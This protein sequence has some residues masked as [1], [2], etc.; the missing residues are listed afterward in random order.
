MLTTIVGNASGNFT[1]DPVNDIV[2]TTITLHNVKQG[3]QLL[4]K[5]SHGIIIYKEEIKNAGTYSKG[6]DL[7][8]L[9]DGNYVFE[10]EKDVEI[11]SIPFKINA[12]TVILNNN[13]PTIFKP[14]ITSKNNYL[15]LTKLALNNEP[16]HVKIY[17]EEDELLYSEKIE[18]TKTIEKAYKLIAPGTYKIVL[19]SNGRTYYQNIKL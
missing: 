16:L 11:K 6:F 5:D 9:P 2:K 7:T 3:N 4:I 14:I 19:A 10:L 15:Y 17:N 18:N 1:S 8:A 12:N 13:E